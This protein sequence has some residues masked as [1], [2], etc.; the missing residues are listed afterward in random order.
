VGPVELAAAI[1]KECNIGKEKLDKKKGASGA[2]ADAHN[3]LFFLLVLENNSSQVVT[4]E[5]PPNN[6][7]V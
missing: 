6:D 2:T 3:I 4:L 5:D 7:N 1:I